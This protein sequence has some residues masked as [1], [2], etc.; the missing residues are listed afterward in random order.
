M[1]DLQIGARAPLSGDS[2]TL[3]IEG[4]RLSEMQSVLG[5]VLIG[6]NA[7]KQMPSAFPPVI[8]GQREMR[9]GIDFNDGGE[10]IIQ[11]AQLPS[12]V[13]R[14]MM[15][16]Y[17]QGG[18]GRGVTFREFGTLTA[19]IG[20]HRFVLDLSSRSDA[21]IIFTEVYRHNGAWKLYANGQ[22]FAGG[23]GAAANALGLTIDVPQP[24]MPP[25]GGGGHGGSGGGY[26]GGG[27]DHM[28][29]PGAK[30]SGSGF[31]VDRRHIIT[32]AHVIH[33]A[34]KVEVASDAVTCPAEI[35][36][37]DPDND[38]ALL[39]VDRDLPATASF[40][41]GFELHLAEDITVV[42]YPLQGLL[43]SGPQATSGNISSLC[44]VHN[45]TSVV[46]F[47]APIASGNSGGP[48]LDSSGLVIAQVT[49]SLNMDKVRSEGS[50][51]ENINFGVKAAAIRSFLATN[52]IHPVTK[53]EGADR[54]RA[55]IVR[56]AR[57]YIFHIRCEA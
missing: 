17:I 9:P 49:S 47:T 8:L 44:G 23:I 21:S 16:L 39:R 51:A 10:P 18:V 31:A 53:P 13:D 27:Q 55:D 24:D 45:D 19:N 25:R 15:I 40:R 33:G 29:P 4:P 30:F 14:L 28:P 50:N 34:S 48:I 37:A 41:D 42:G 32:N 1:A 43:G 12:D 5:A 35:I 56:E 26:D 54:K 46:Q 7:A 52:S 22:G 11:F 2:V 38:V 3:N 57:S 20:D 6:L 36:F